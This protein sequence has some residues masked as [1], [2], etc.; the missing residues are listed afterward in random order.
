[1]LHIFPLPVW[2]FAFK[3]CCVSM[4]LLLN[5][6]ELLLLFKSK[7]LLLLFEITELDAVPACVKLDAD[8]DDKDAEEANCSIKFCNDDEFKIGAL[9]GTFWLKLSALFDLSCCW[10]CC[11]CCCWNGEFEVRWSTGKSDGSNG[12]NESVFTLFFKFFQSERKKNKKLSS[13][14]FFVV[15]LN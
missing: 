12:E 9:L 10:S 4:L 5:C 8:E 1:M 7:L 3:D 11:N 2:L 6:N 14:D 15:V 13:F